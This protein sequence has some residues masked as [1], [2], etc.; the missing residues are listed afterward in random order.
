MAVL[1]KALHLLHHYMC[2]DVPQEIFSDTVEV[3]KAY[4]GGQKKNKK[5]LYG[6]I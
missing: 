6:E 5:N 3:D 2:Q 1:G 4:L